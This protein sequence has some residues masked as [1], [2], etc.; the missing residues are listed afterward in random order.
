VVY[1]SVGS[2]TFEDSLRSLAT[3]GT[4]VL[5]GQSSGPVPPFDLSRLGPAGSLTITRP[6][7]RHFV[8]TEAEL[9]RRADALFSLVAEGVLVPR[10]GAIY[11]LAAT[12]QAHQALQSRQTSGKVL[13]VPDPGAA[14]APGQGPGAIAW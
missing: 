3:R 13:L 11:P 6:T 2:T 8:S 12:E 14:I 10:V 9:R 7:L 1:D 4:L 5:Y